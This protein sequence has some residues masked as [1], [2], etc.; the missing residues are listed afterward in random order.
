MEKAS[1]N[2]DLNI[3]QWTLITPPGTDSVIADK[4][5][6]KFMNVLKGDQLVEKDTYSIAVA[7]GILYINGDKQAE[8]INNKY[9]K[10]ITSTG[11]FISK[12][13]KE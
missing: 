9:S 8:E 1:A 6:R 5:V 11:D 12:E 2:T 10:Y 13:S 3:N 4:E 7:K